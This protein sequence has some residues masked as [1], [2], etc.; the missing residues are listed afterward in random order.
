MKK[1]EI[2]NI[3]SYYNENIY[4]QPIDEYG[5]IVDGYDCIHYINGKILQYPFN[6]SLS[7]ISKVTKTYLVVDK[8]KEL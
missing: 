2:F 6:K 8:Q 7:E 5:N 4:L 3:P 1:I